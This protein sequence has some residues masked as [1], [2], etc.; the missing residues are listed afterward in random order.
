TPLSWAASSG[1]VEASEILLKTGKVDPNLQDHEGRTPLSWAVSKGNVGVLEI[2]LKASE[3]TDGTLLPAA[4]QQQ[5]LRR[6]QA[7]RPGVVAARR[8]RHS[9]PGKAPRRRLL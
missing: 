3:D 5:L 6:G 1:Q 2:L 8:A 4:L 7:D 9:C